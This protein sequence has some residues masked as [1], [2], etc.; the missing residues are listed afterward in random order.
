MEP[1]RFGTNY[2]LHR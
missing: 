1:S 2:N